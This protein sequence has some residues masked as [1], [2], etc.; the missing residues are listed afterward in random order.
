[1]VQGGINVSGRRKGQFTFQRD[2][3][4]TGETLYLLGHSTA[5]WA[6]DTS[7]TITAISCWLNV[8]T[9]GTSG[10]LELWSDTTASG[11]AVF[12]AAVATG[13]GEVTGTD[14]VAASTAGAYFTTAEAIIVLA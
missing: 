12:S 11:S 3:V 9:D 5:G 6:P 1:M 10:T 7:I 2:A 14:T 13:T 4:A 8:S